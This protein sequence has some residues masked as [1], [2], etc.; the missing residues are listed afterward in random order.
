MPW[1]LQ[2]NVSILACYN[3]ESVSSV[4]ITANAMNMY[5]GKD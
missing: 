2:S 1:G 4:L 5:S 3:L